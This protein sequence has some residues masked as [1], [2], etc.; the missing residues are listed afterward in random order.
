MSNHA[1]VCFSCHV[2]F[3]RS[4]GAANVRCSHCSKACE[5]LGAKTP[6]PPK[7]KAKAWEQLRI[8]Y[9][10]AKHRA[11]LQQQRAR[12]R[13]THDLEQEIVRLEV[14]GPNHGRA[15]AIKQLKRRLSV[16]G[17]RRA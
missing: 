17:V 3:R 1:W 4:S 16:L 8:A 2:A 9:Y 12:V 14:K 6:I 13:R 15:A 5:W 10:R 11:L 7:S